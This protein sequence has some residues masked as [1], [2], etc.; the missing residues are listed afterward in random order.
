MTTFWYRELWNGTGCKSEKNLTVF[1][2][3]PCILQWLQ[4]LEPVLQIAVDDHKNLVCPQTLK[5]SYKSCTLLQQNYQIIFLQGCK[6]QSLL[7]HFL[8]LA[9]Y[10]VKARQLAF[11]LLSWRSLKIYCFTWLAVEL[12]FFLKLSVFLEEHSAWF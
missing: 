2:L 1:T 11:I 4:R 10:S 9:F 7:E 5:T 3:I 12:R 8:L 6:R